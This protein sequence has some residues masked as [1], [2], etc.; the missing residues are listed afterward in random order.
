MER[1]IIKGVDK[2]DVSEDPIPEDVV[3]EISLIIRDPSGIDQNV[4][5]RKEFAE[6]IRLVCEAVQ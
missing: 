5:N 1:F 4:D 2:V 3:Y 6:A